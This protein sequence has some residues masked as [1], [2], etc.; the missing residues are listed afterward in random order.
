MAYYVPPLNIAGKWSLKAPFTASVV[1]NLIYTCIS[2]RTFSD[3]ESS[4]VDVL[5]DLYI[6]RTLTN[7]D[8]LSDKRNGAVIVTLEATTGNTISVPNS[9]INAAPDIGG[10]PYQSVILA[11]SLSLLPES[12]DLSN[13]KA[14]IETDV[15]D[16]IG[17]DSEVK[18]IIAGG[19]MALTKEQAALA[20]SSRQ[21]NIATSTTDYA[22][23]LEFKTKYER[24]Q[25]QVAALSAYIIAN[26]I[27]PPP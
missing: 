18:E 21:Q 16:L 25:E 13:I 26:N 14:K 11:I 24:S 7:D 2:V 15:K 19:R 8:Y 20:E 17:V 10:V 4:G 9:Y 12:A 1:P 5:E 3:L 27:T 22:R 23:Y 6:P